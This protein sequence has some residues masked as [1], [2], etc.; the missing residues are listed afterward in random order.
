MTEV[1]KHPPNPNNRIAK[2]SEEAESQSQSYAWLHSLKPFV[3]IR[4]FIMEI[5]LNSKKRGACGGD[6]WQF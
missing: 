1:S 2:I 6:K 3:I 4:V 5:E